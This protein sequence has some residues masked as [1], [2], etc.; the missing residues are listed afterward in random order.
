M[1]IS[2]HTNILVRAVVQDDPVQAKKAITILRDASLI[3][4]ALPSLCE[5]VWVLRRVYG[6]KTVDIS[7]AIRALGTTANL[8]VNREAMSAGL[9]MLEDGGDFADGVIAHEGY[10]LGAETFVFLIKRRLGDWLRAGS[11]HGYFSESN[12]YRRSTLEPARRHRSEQ[13][14]TCS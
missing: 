10:C 9:A 12:L 14:F 8:E 7:Q 4:V 1:K 5:L 6:F 11:R 3:A 13:Y 2:V